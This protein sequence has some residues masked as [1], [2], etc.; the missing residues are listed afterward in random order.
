[1][2][3]QPVVQIQCDR[4]KRVQLLPVGPEKAIPDF[5][6]VFNNKQI[7]Y[8]DLCEHCKKTIDNIWIELEQWDREV[9]QSLL[10]GPTVDDNK[11]PPME[12]APDFTPPKPH[13]A[14]GA[15]RS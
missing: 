2:A 11:A 4:C 14:A 12:V 13:S 7:I 1:M 10:A 8:T 6:A 5:H 9:K 15:K 3:R